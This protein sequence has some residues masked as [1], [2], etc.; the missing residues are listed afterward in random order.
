MTKY[1]CPQLKVRL[2]LK[3]CPIGDCWASH[4]FSS[5]A[6]WPW[7]GEQ[8]PCRGEQTP[9]S[10]CSHHKVVQYHRCNTTWPSA[11]IF[12]NHEPSNL[13]SLLVDCLRYFAVVMKAGEK[14]IPTKDH[15]WKASVTAWSDGEGEKGQGFRPSDGYLVTH[16]KVP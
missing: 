10:L 6:L 8:T 1:T 14:W 3:V 16:H 5:L 12:W 13:S 4:P 11:Y 2:Y 9:C 7:W 15:G